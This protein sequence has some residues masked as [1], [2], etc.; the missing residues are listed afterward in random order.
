MESCNYNEHVIENFSE[1]KKM[2]KKLEEADDDY[3]ENFYEELDIISYPYLIRRF[4]KFLERLMN[5]VEEI[6]F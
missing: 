1:L 4:E 2:E 5:K 6:E 3:I